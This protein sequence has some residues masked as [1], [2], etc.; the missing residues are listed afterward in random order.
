MNGGQPQKE[1]ALQCGI[2]R[3]TTVFE[4]KDLQTLTDLACAFVDLKV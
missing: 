3:E 2:A 1:I 4:A